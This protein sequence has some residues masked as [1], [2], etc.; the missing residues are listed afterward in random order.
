MINLPQTQ[1][2][3]F[4]IFSRIDYSKVTTITTIVTFWIVHQASATISRIFNILVFIN[5]EKLHESKSYLKYKKYSSVKDL[6]INNDVARFISLGRDGWVDALKELIRNKVIHDDVA[7]K[8][9]WDNSDMWR[10]GVRVC[11]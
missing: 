11:L 6:E 3:F 1:G 10:R 9:S 8:Q 7:K 2:A 4:V 5:I